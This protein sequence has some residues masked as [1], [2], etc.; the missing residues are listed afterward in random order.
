M[1]RIGLFLLVNILVLTTI[2][3]IT[4][5]LGVGSYI[6]EYGIDYSSLLVFSAIVGFSG[7]FI[8]LAISR[9][10]A[11]KMMNVR[12]LDPKGNLSPVEREIVDQVH[13]MARNSGI[14][15]MPEVGIYNSPE[16]NA[17]ATGPT[18]N[19]SLVAVSAGLLQSLDRDAVEGV[20]AHEVA[21]ISN[22]DM[23]TMALIQGVINTFVVFLSR[24]AAFAV[25]RF[26][27]EKM[28]GLVHFLA[29][30][31]FQILFG[32][33]GSIAVMAFSRRREFRADQGGADL[34][35]KDK[36]IT[37]LEQLKRNV[38]MVQTDKESIQT[39]KINGGPSK[40]MKLFSSHPDL[41]DRIRSLRN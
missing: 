1:K 2:V 36:M 8:S 16:V 33:L 4:S 30:I 3:V 38:R 14:A 24:V 6:T 10:M 21:H 7:S 9:W 40:M 17:F 26:V 39:F 18:K 25:S 32:I 31:I 37:A 28:A 13:R 27:D 19:K 22:G 41:D 12:V 11:K 23:V 35:G 34:A 5:V 15:V 20:L 29:I